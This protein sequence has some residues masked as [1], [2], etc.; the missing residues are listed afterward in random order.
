MARVLLI[1]DCCDSRA[2]ARCLLEGEGLEV[3]EARDALAGLQRSVEDRPDCVVV[4]ATLP[5]LDGF[6]VAGR[7]AREGATAGLPVLVSCDR[8]DASLRVAAR[9]AGARD[10]VVRSARGEDLAGPV[11]E[12]LWAAGVTWVAE[13][14]LRAADSA[15][16]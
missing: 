5:G 6:D 9:A 10:L 3:I 16:C 4:A 12:A 13:G 14:P 8:S 11:R 7:I 15:S 2:Q 1:D